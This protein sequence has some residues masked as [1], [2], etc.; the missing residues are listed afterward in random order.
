MK[1]NIYTFLL[2]KKEIVASS[3]LVR[4]EEK[5]VPTLSLC[6]HLRSLS[7]FPVLH[8]SPATR[9]SPRYLI[10]YFGKLGDTSDLKPGAEA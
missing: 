9:V 1:E 6:A 5:T 7:R 3:R 4:F 8:L 2:D 10:F